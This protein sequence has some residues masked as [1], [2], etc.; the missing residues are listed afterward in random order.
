MKVNKRDADNAIHY[1][2]KEIAG[3]IAALLTRCN[4]RKRDIVEKVNSED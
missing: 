1:L 3:E 4:G 2:K